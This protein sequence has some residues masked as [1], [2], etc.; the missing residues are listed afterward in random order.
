MREVNI[1]V[2]NKKKITY[3]KVRR[4]ISKWPS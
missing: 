1:I 2:L 3:E 4:S